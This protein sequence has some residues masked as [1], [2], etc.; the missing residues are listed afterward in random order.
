MAKLGRGTR[1]HGWLQQELNQF[2][3]N[4]MRQCF[5]KDLVIQIPGAG[6]R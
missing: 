4:Q 2:W 5:A 6:K 3:I 1:I